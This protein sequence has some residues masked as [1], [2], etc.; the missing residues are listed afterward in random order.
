M[1][2]RNCLVHL[3][4]NVPA[5]IRT[6]ADSANI[7]GLADRDAYGSYWLSWPT[8]GVLEPEQCER[9]WELA[10]QS[11]FREHAWQLYKILWRIALT[12]TQQVD[13]SNWADKYASTISAYSVGILARKE[14]V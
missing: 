12:G 5:R 14:H 4:G 3:G 10:K 8:P 9:P 11:A 1:V 2:W 7:V 6:D 13:A